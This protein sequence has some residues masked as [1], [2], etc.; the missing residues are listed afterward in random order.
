MDTMANEKEHLRLRALDLI[1]RMKSAGF[2]GAFKTNA[3]IDGITYNVV[4]EKTENARFGIGFYWHGG[5]D[6]IRWKV[7]YDGVD[8]CEEYEDLH[9]NTNDELMDILEEYNRG[10]HFIIAWT[11]LFGK[12]RAYWLPGEENAERY[13]KRKKYT[14]YRI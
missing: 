9:T 6:H 3:D 1:D 12:K 8:E 13:R 10:E 11:G 7:C 5:D 4:W 14:I 2:K